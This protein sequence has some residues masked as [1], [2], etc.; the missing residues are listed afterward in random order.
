MRVKKCKRSVE[1]V[2]SDFIDPDKFKFILDL[3]RPDNANAVRVCLYTGLR[4]NDVLTLKKTDLSQD[5]TVRTVCSKT[6]KPFE[7]K[8]P[9]KLAAD[10][11]HRS[12]KSSA[13]LFPS[14][15]SSRLHRTRQTVWANVKRAARICAVPRNVTPHSARKIYAVEKFRKFGLE[16][17]QEALQHD[18]E[19]TTLIYAFS[20]ILSKKLEE[21]KM[22]E[23]KIKSL[24]KPEDEDY[25]TKV[26]NH[27]ADQEVCAGNVRRLPV[28]ANLIISDFLRGLLELVLHDER[29]AESLLSADS[30]LYK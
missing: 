5:G 14:P 9:V 25:Y 18:R 8:I 11:L 1:K 29:F 28:G 21:A 2:K 16:E 24:P 19:S 30:D 26:E 4:I 17:A 15:K 27:E 10:I 6:K 20:D 23:E 3:M 13:W 12:A 7:G 22:A